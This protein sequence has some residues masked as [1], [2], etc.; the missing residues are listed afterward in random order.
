MDTQF[1]LPAKLILVLPHV[2]PVTV[3]MAL[4]LL[5]TFRALVALLLGLLT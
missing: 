3:E 5:Q 1:S 2:S 4:T